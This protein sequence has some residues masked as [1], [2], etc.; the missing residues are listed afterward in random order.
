[1]EALSQ[2]FRPLGRLLQLVSGGR[3]GD[4]F[5]T[6]KSERSERVLKGS[7]DHPQRLVPK[8]STQAADASPLR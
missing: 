4:L 8:A 3:S 5:K 7:P 2:S 6:L 1:M